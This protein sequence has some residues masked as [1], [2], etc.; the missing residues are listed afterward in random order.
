MLRLI[1]AT[2][3]RVNPA[4]GRQAEAALV[5]DRVDLTFDATAIHRAYPDL[6]TTSLADLLAISS[7]TEACPAPRRSGRAP[8]EGT[9]RSVPGNLQSE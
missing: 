6:P 1:D 7:L 3:G 4:L 9:I 8:A 2:I 5:M